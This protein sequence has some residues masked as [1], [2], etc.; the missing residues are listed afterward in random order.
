M[1]I[2]S[3]AGTNLNG[4]IIVS[5]GGLCLAGRFAPGL[6]ATPGS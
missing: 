6:G 4:S 1:F 3:D 2:L 5:D